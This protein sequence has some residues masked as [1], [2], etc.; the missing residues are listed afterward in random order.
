MQQLLER[1]SSVMSPHGIGVSPADVGASVT[2]ASEAPHVVA[3]RPEVDPGVAE[4]CHDGIAN[5]P[6]AHASQRPATDTTRLPRQLLGDR[7]IALC[8][9]SVLGCGGHEPERRNAAPDPIWG[10]LPGVGTNTASDN[11]ELN[12]T[13]GAPARCVTGAAGEIPAPQASCSALSE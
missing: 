1:G 4:R 5:N 9:I 12:P 2:H 6:L 10:A 13:S 7:S 8:C 11:T 3:G